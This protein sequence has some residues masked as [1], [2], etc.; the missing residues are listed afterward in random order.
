MIGKV[1]VKLFWVVLP[2]LVSLEIQTWRKKRGG[3]E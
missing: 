3:K 2:E 1:L